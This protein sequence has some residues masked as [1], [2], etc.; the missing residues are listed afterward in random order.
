MHRLPHRAND[1]PL[2]LHTAG[3]TVR[4]AHD[5]AGR[6]VARSLDTGV[7]LAQV[8]DAN[9][10]LLSQTVTAG[11]P[12]TA[13]H[14]RVLQRRD[15]SYSPDGYVS[16][17]D[18]MLAGLRRF[19][20]DPVRRVTAVHGTDWQERYA[21]DV[22]GNITDAS[23]SVPAQRDGRDGGDHAA[24]GG[25][26]YAGT[27]IRRAGRV[28][29]EHDGQGR[30]TLRQHKRLSGKPRTWRYSWDAD[31]RLTGVTTPEGQRWRYSYDPF[32]R[33][34][35][36]QR[37]TSTGDGGGVTEQVDFAWDGVVLA[38]QHH[39]TTATG[40]DPAPSVTTWDWEPGGFRPLTQSERRP[41]ETA[42]GGKPGG[43]DTAD[44][45][46]TAGQA[47][48]DARFHAIVTDLV[49]TPTELVDP[50]GEL[51]W[52]AR[53][54]LWG[55]HQSPVGQDVDCPL[56]FPGQYHDP[57]TGA[58][59]NY[60]RYYDPEIARY[61]S[62]D[63]LGLTPAPNPHTYVPNPTWEF[64]P[65]GL[66]PYDISFRSRQEALNAA[67]DRAGIP[68]GAAPDLQWEVGGEPLR[69]GTPDYRYSEDVGAQGRYMQ[70]ETESGSRVLAE[71]TKDP[72]RG[73]HF[74]AGQPKGGDPNRTSVDFGWGGNRDFERY[75]QIG[76]KHHLLY[77]KG[78]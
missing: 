50:D 11:R 62:I 30:V 66:A 18:D 22:A 55:V 65:L 37:L 59:Y 43:D 16:E 38:E 51:A 63:P 2:S 7:V 13:G 41:S 70:F 77:P 78:K 20:L 31:D 67:Y 72:T 64:D 71:H 44:D 1:L 61:E 28:R 34:I 40:G 27:L 45:H 17:I 25:R 32:G 8:W 19:D 75:Q 36:K 73:P 9:H 10:Q 53:T 35:A 69:R 46:D 5:A 12:G 60:H 39:H 42:V 33:R 57:E 29:Y 54:T 47:W 6:E 48:F 49:G 68:R 23:W 15:Y 4:F 56:R 74:H 14:T 3:R 21:Y 58:H 76:G 24:Q 26:E 52:Q